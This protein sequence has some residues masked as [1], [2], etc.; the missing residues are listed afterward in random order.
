MP[1]YG[2]DEQAD[3]QLHQAMYRD[4]PGTHPLDSQN[5]PVIVF[6][7]SRRQTRL[8][9]L[10]LIN[11]AAAENPFQFLKMDQN[12]ME[13]ICQQIKDENLRQTLMFGVGIHHAGLNAS[14]RIIVE[15][16]FSQEKIQILC[17]TST[18]AW[19]VNLPAYMVVIKGTEYH[20]PKTCRFVDYPITDVLQ[21]MGRAGRPQ[22][23][24]EGVGCVL[25]HDIKKSYYKKFLYEPFP[26]ESSLHK[27]LPDHINAEIAAGTLTNVDTIL[28][29]LSYTFLFRRLVSNPSYYGVEVNEKSKEKKNI[30]NY[31]KSLITNTLSSLANAGC[32]EILEKNQIKATELGRIASF[33]YLHYQSMPIFCNGLK[34]VNSIQS[35]VYLLSDASEYDEVPVRHSEDEVDAKLNKY[36]YWP[37]PSDT[38]F[39]SAHVKANELIQ[40]FMMRLELPVVDY[41]NDQNSVMDQSIRIVNALIEVCL[42]LKYY[43]QL[44]LLMELSPLLI[45]GLLPDGNELLQIKDMDKRLAED[46]SKRNGCS[47]KKLL[48]MSEEEL[49]KLFTRHGCSKEKALKVCSLTC[50]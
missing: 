19:G 49:H 10:A 34:K 8:T 21:M 35:L 46:L 20:D 7:S 42:H 24:K 17:S 39:E 28:D 27:Q 2:H 33:Y 38:N 29:Y 3:V 26:V 40:A 11:F 12:D 31:M 45:Q 36:I 9:A 6:V 14:D 22:F 5:K 18:L 47:L 16:L 23:D 13:V 37:L 25:V 43:P 50:N 32:I 41:Y 15:R 1:A 30:L 48:E 44:D 4:L